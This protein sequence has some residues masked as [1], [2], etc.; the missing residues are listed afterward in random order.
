MHQAIIW[1]NYPRA[2]LCILE[3]WILFTV[4]RK[5]VC[6]PSEPITHSASQ[7]IIKS[8]SM[9]PSSSWGVTLLGKTQPAWSPS[10]KFVTLYNIYLCNIKKDYHQQYCSSSF[11]PTITTSERN[12]N[13][14]PDFCRHTTLLGPNE[15]DTACLSVQ[16]MDFFIERLKFKW[17]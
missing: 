2:I 12:C 5:Y 4:I 15:L 11:L 1:N 16:N 14:D 17:A 13:A 9:P 6:A 3:F 7:N 10:W 8:V